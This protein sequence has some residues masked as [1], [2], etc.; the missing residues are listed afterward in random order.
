[1]QKS[2]NK[3]VHFYYAAAK[4][5]YLFKITKLFNG[6]FGVLG[7]KTHTVV[8]LYVAITTQKHIYLLKTVVFGR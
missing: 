8:I 2:N 5:E 3:T 6:F 7:K 1:M 4:L